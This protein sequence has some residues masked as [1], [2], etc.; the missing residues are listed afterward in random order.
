MTPLIK[1]TTMEGTE[2][3]LNMDHVVLVRPHR[4]DRGGTGMR[5]A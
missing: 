3:R 4:G 2:I 5:N 1:C